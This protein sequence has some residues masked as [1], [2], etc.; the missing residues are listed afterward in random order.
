MPRGLAAHRSDDF[1]PKPTSARVRT[2]AEL[3]PLLMRRSSLRR[4][5]AAF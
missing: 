4:Y 3:L 2:C 5:D 1:D